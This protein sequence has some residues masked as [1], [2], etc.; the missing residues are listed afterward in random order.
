MS[1]FLFS[2]T[3]EANQ[4]VLRD[5]EIRAKRREENRVINFIKKGGWMDLLP[6]AVTVLVYIQW[7]TD[8]GTHED[9]VSCCEFHW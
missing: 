3:P 6:S 7:L 9:N 1:Y 2:L 5:K 8:F 4:Q